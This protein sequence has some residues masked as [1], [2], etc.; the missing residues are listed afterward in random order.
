MLTGRI[1]LSPT[2][3]GRGA[4]FPVLSGSSFE[5]A[6][7]LLRMGGEREAAASC[8]DAALQ[9]GPQGRVMEGVDGR[10]GSDLPHLLRAEAREHAEG[11]E[12]RALGGPH[13][14]GRILEGD[15]LF[16]F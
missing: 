16:G 4:A 11:K 14:G 12:A 9:N 15:G 13:P 7:G 10:V 6:S 3:K 8:G 1:P 2:R 5:T